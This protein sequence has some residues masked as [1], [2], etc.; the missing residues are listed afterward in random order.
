MSTEAAA[1]AAETDTSVQNA[2]SKVDAKPSAG[3]PD[4]LPKRIEQAKR[5]AQSELLASL[6]VDK[7]EDLKA[8]FDRLKALDD[9]RK[10]AAQKAE[11][12]LN[13]LRPKATRLSTVEAELK[14]QA[15]AQLGGL[16]EDRKAAVLELAGDDPV[17]QMRAIRTLSKTWTKAGEAK[18]LAAPADTSSATKPPAAA[19]PGS[20]DV[21][22]TYASLKDT[23]PIAAAD[24][25]LRNQLAYTAAKT[26]K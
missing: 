26:K 8:S 11:E 3:E 2:E 23:N 19:K 7:V 5:A 1:T 22:A 16:G 12:E 10:T 14:A 15:D 25:L 17:A 13:S 21:L 9:E 4:W 20:E 6:G 24:Y 18:P